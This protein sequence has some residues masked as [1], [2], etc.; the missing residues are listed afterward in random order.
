MHKIAKVNPYQSKG[1]MNQFSN[2]DIA[3]QI[4]TKNQSIS[5][6]LI[7]NLYNLLIINLFQSHGDLNKIKI[8]FLF[9]INNTNILTW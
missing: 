5:D 4:G 2:E 8:F 9:F 7:K 3:R 6:K 1:K